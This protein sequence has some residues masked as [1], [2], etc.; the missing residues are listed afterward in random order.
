MKNQKTKI[1][2]MDGKHKIPTPPRKK[3]AK[4]TPNIPG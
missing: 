2:E 1:V 3:I 4:W